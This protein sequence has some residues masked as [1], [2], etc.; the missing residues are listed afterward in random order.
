MDTRATPIERITTAGSKTSDADC[1]FDL[2]L[3]A[4]GFDAAT[5][6]HNRID[7]RGAGGLSLQDQWSTGPR[8]L[9]GIQSVGF[10]NLFI[11]GGPQNATRFCNVPRCLEQ[12]VEW[13]SATI[14]YMREHQLTRIA[15]TTAAEAAW[16]EHVDE[17]V[18]DTLIP[19]TDSWFMGANI[20]GKQRAVLLYAGGLP[21]FR[22]KCAEVA[23]Q[24]YAGFV[25]E[26]SRA[27]RSWPARG[28][29]RATIGVSIVLFAEPEPQRQP[30][31]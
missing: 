2:I 6:A 14:R 29:G 18:A 3:F 24:G 8:T 31:G 13:V 23:A 21:T 1:A 17:T 30:P 16:V 15:A 11:G 9:L 25:L 22:Q 7:L 10:P 28:V 26:R 20:P 27:R 4:I 5:G 12:N 19:E